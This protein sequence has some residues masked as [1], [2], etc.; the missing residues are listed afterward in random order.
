MKGNKVQTR[1][2]RFSFW[3][4]IT[5]LLVAPA[6]RTACMTVL[7]GPQGSGKTSLVR[8]WKESLQELEGASRPRVLYS[9]AQAR[10]TPKQFC[11]RLLR[12]MGREPSGGDV[13]EL[14]D[15]LGATLRT[16]SDLLI[17]DQAER[18][19]LLTAQYLR[20]Y[21][22]D[23]WGDSLC[24]VGRPALE[25]LLRSDPYIEDRVGAWHSIEQFG[26][27]TAAV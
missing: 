27:A 8:L 10:E 17:I 12:E 20:S 23:K 22:F 21:A 24:F 9:I 11:L 2:E 4:S 13:H 6:R 25:T 19:A 14:M 7:V 16:T 18:M 3:M 5:Q 15:E 1:E 26:E